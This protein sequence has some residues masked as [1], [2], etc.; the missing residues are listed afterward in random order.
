MSR[1]SIHRYT[2]SNRNPMIALGATVLALTLISAPLGQSSIS[3]SRHT[4]RQLATVIANKQGL[5]PKLVRAVVTVES[6]WRPGA[7]SR[8]DALGLMQVHHPTWR[9]KHT[10]RELLDPELNLIVG[11]QILKSYIKNSRNLRDALT[12][13]SGG[14]PEY[15]DKVMKANANEGHI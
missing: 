10:R 15:Y 6:S 3:L 11:T 9:H 5:D 14:E 12:K 13:Y 7:R 2:K 4:L 1:P 8:K